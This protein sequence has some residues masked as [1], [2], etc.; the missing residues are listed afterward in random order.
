MFKPYK[1]GKTKEKTPIYDLSAILEDFI[2][3]QKRGGE[4]VSFDEALLFFKDE[5]LDPLDKMVV[6]GELDPL[7]K[8]LFVLTRIEFKGEQSFESMMVDMQ[9][10]MLLSL[11]ANRVKGEA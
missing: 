8:P 4:T 3:T 1:I 7:E 10:K 2:E 9:Q 5:Y 6:K 11:F